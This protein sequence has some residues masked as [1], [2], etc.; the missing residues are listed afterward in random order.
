MEVL[1][2]DLS[3][4]VLFKDRYAV[5]PLIMLNACLTLSWLDK[6][7]RPRS[8]VCYCWRMSVMLAMYWNLCYCNLLK[9]MLFS[10]IDLEIQ[11]CTIICE[12]HNIISVAFSVYVTCIYLIMW[13]WCEV[14]LPGSFMALNVLSGLCKWE[15]ACVS[16]LSGDSHTQSCINWA[17]PSQMLMEVDGFGT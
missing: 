13:S 12:L 15:Y 9:A 5:R 3:P 6:S 2:V 1:G 4:S 16:V 10:L 7:V 17:V 11:T 14:D 8:R